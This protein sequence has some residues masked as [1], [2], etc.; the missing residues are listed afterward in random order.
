[1]AEL[2]YFIT[3]NIVIFLIAMRIASSLRRQTLEEAAAAYSSHT[4]LF[5]AALEVMAPLF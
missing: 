2:R 4:L 5:F 1:M 3:F